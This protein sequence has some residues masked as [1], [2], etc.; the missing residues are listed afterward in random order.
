M[1]AGRLILD[2]SIPSYWPVS[3]HSQQ[4][5]EKALKALLIR[6]QIPFEK[7]H[8]LRGLL[9]LAEPATPGISSMLTD[10]GTLTPYAVNTRYPGTPA[11]SREEAGRHLQLARKVLD[12]VS[13]F[14]KA[15][16]DAGRPDG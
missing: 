9:A 10:A 5:A 7:T 13:T 11:P 16:L 12:S 3:F 8:D 1:I 15:Y 4:A 2:G 6:Q 14:L